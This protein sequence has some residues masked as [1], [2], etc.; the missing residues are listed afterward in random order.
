MPRKPVL[1]LVEA[2]V[3][4]VLAA[5][6]MDIGYMGVASGPAD[7]EGSGMLADATSA[8]MEKYTKTAV[9]VEVEVVVDTENF[10]TAL[11]MSYR[12]EWAMGSDTQR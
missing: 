11:A 2:V 9:E 12:E 7:M 3:V 10:E 6:M 1:V 5:G 8:D 4:S